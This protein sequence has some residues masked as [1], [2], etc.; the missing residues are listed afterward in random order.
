MPIVRF[1][2]SN[3]VVGGADPP[4]ERYVRVLIL[5][6]PP[7]DV[8]AASYG[9]ATVD[10][11]HVWQALYVANKLGE[12]GR[13]IVPSPRERQRERHVQIDHGYNNNRFRTPPSCGSKHPPHAQAGRYET[14]D[15]RLV[16][17]LL[18][19]AGRLQT[20]A[21]TFAHH[22]VV[23]ARVGPPWKPDKRCIHQI[24]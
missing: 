23:E 16:H 19:D 13:R 6:S 21:I 2:G 20:A 8:T 7:H 4:C 14:Q 22:A 9:G 10:C 5:V 3:G 12:Q 18:N 11:S 1:S 15:R 24:S 17:S